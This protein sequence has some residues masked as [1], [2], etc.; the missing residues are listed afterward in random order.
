MLHSHQLIVGPVEGVGKGGYLL[1]K[2]REGV[3]DHSPACA[4]TTSKPFLQWGHSTFRAWVPVP[5][6]RL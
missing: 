6:I 5:L 4:G 3:A 1:V 2:L